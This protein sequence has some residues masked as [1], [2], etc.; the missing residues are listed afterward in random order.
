MSKNYIFIKYWLILLAFFLIP[1]LNIQKIN[2]QKIN[3]QE[4]KP[5]QEESLKEAIKLFGQNK[6]KESANIFL[7]IAKE[8]EDP[9]AF[10]YLGRIYSEGLGGIK[11]Q[12]KIGFEYYK[13]AFEKKYVPA[14]TQYAIYYLTGEFVLQDFN[15]AIQLL[16]E[17]SKTD[18]NANLVLGGLFTNGTIVKKNLRKAFQNYKKAGEKGNAL[19]SYHIGRFY[20]EGKYVSKNSKTAYDWYHKSSTKN[21]LPAVLKLAEYYME[22]I[23]VK[24]NLVY[25]HVYYN[26]ASSLGST[27]AKQQLVEIGKQLD[28][29]EVLNAQKT[30]RR[31]R[32]NPSIKLK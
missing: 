24:K 32:K 14:Q 1:L 2:I 4:K 28:I 30:A 11:P 29:S 22:G 7:Q 19:A 18:T 13:R 9:E 23:V 12:R 27:Q 3:A 5:S 15:K 20:E 25:A 8:N 26:I 16:E 21:F 31:I 17:A 6:I 10:Y